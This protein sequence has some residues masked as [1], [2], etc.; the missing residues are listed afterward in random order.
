MWL[1]GSLKV[2]NLESALCLLKSSDECCDALETSTTVPVIELKPFKYISPVTEFRIVLSSGQL[3]YIVQ[4]HYH[5]FYH[6]LY[7]HKQEIIHVCILF[8][9]LYLMT[10]TRPL[11]GTYFLTLMMT[12]G[13]MHVLSSLILN[14][15]ALARSLGV[16]I[17]FLLPQS[18]CIVSVAA[19]YTCFLEFVLHFFHQNKVDPFF[20]GHRQLLFLL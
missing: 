1:Y 11:S 6:P 9:S 7:D 20:Q 4:R 10:L 14:F 15:G 3:K 8:T 12:I 13:L 18:I 5:Q 2:H 17:A 16:I 19:N